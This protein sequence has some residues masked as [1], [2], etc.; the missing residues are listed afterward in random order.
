MADLAIGIS[1]TAVEAL[2]NKVKTAINEE[3]EL[4]QIGQ[5][6]TLFMKDEF[7]MMQSFLKTA[8]WEQVKNT[9]GR[10]WVRQVRE[11]PY[12]AEDSV[13]SIILLDCSENDLM[14]YFNILF[15]RLMTHTTLGLI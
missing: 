15:W 14:L 5:R 2:V 4:W 8:D 3:A 10:T 6:D 13:E 1:M 12:G 7:E 11:L 9:V